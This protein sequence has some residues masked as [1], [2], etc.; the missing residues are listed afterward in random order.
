MCL[1]KMLCLLNVGSHCHI[2]AWGS[3]N[4][5]SAVLMLA[6]TNIGITELSSAKVSLH[7]QRFIVIH[8]DNTCLIEQMHAYGAHSVAMMTQVCGEA[9][10]SRV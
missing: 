4:W 6:G 2:C 5:H 10:K 1:V 7:S 8:N 9:F 3:F